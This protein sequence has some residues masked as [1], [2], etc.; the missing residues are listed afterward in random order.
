MRN[1]A[2]QS[3]LEKPN[4]PETSD[5]NE[6]WKPY[7]LFSYAN[8]RIVEDKLALFSVPVENMTRGSTDH[9]FYSIFLLFLLVSYLGEIYYLG[10][11]LEG[12]N[13]YFQ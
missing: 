10:Q 8:L 11:N 12:L 6:P 1:R 9:W 2:I 7:R 3:K 5:I 4:P 13:I